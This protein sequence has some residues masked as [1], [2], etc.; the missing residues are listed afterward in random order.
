MFFA[1][2]IGFYK[3]YQI[4]NYTN[5]IKINGVYAQKDYICQKIAPGTQGKFVISNNKEK[6][7]LYV[8]EN[9]KK[10]SN[11]YFKIG[12]KMFN[13]IKEAINYINDE[14]LDYVEIEWSWEYSKDDLLDTIDGLNAENYLVEIYEEEEVTI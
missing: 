10:P 9:N 8:N 7:K 11:M 3:Q 14:K 6:I 5:E 2:L 13:D 12:N 1:F 4:F